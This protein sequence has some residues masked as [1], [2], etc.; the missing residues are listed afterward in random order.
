M[1]LTFSGGIHADDCKITENC[2]IIDMPEPKTVSI[3]MSQHIGLPCEPIVSVGDNVKK[4]QKIGENIN[5]LSSYI[6]SSI[7]GKVKAIETRLDNNGK[8]IK[9]IVI[10]NDFKSEVCEN[11]LPFNK[12]ITDTTTEEIIE[13]VK[14]AG[15]IGM[16]GAA[17][18]SHA[19]IASAINK[20]DTLIINCSECEPYI[21]AN[22]RLLLESPEKVIG[23]AKI[24]L[25][26]LNISTGFLAVE[27]NKPTAIKILNELLKNDS[28]LSVKVLKTKYPQGDER[29]LIYA[30]KKKE[31][32]AGKLPADLG[33][34]IFNA[35]TTASIFTAFST[36]M[37][38]VNRIVT[39]SGNCIAK[40]QN[41]RVPI[42][43]SFSDVID[44]CGGFTTEPDKVV[45]GGP[46]MGFAQW[47]I[48]TPVVKGTTAILALSEVCDEKNVSN[49]IHCGR[50]INVCPMH[51]M[52]LYFAAYAKK[53]NYLRCNE[54]NVLSCVECGCCTYICPGKVPIVQYIR[55]AKAK[56]REQK[57]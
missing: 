37:P 38:I 22:H 23:G 24:I 14:N 2:P 7:S 57:R 10:E 29:Q 25:K 6:H 48:S 8:K 55:T 40:P 49:C 45:S 44:F 32:P 26:A 28:L 41:V 53:E 1:A 35:E 11:I 43:T 27:D 5:G 16:G 20:A 39:V 18:P 50:C 52:P 4:G 17:F 47:D 46:M 13:I 31:L 12:K 15:I 19:K 56:I 30:I 9:C 34:V 51:L 36:G 3:P 54:Y 42:G 21:T 33:C